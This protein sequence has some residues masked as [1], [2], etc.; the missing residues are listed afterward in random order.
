MTNTF[1]LRAGALGLFAA[2]ALTAAWPVAAQPTTPDQPT[3]TSRLEVAAK[4]A[5]HRLAA[6]TPLE[7]S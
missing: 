5:L 1:H 3:C 2:I 4:C 7:E 6:G